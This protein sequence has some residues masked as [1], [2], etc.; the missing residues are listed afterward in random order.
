MLAK[1]LGA[2]T[3]VATYLAAGVLSS[4]GGMSIKL[5]V[6]SATPSLGASGAVRPP[7]PL[8]PYRAGI[9]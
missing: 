7:Y 4:L 2:E 3:F 6:K 9:G 1:S 5:A 8:L